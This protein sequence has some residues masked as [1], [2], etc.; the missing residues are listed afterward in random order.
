MFQEIEIKTMLLVK[1]RM[2]PRLKRVSNFFLWVIVWT[3][4][5]KAKIMKM[6]IGTAAM[7]PKDIRS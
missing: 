3:T 6:I 5:Q 4:F 1:L 2:L 7:T